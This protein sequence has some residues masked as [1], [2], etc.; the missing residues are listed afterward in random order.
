M[1]NM[2]CCIMWIL[3]TYLV[4]LHSMENN[5]IPL[6]INVLCDYSVHFGYEYRNVWKPLSL[7]NTHYYKKINDEFFKKALIA[8]YLPKLIAPIL[9]AL[10]DSPERK[11]KYNATAT[12]CAWKQ[13]F[14]SEHLSAIITDYDLE[15]QTYTL[16]YPDLEVK[17]AF[18]KYLLEAFAQ[19]DALSVKRLSED[20]WRSLNNANADEVI[21]V[22]KQLFAHVPYQLHMKEEKFY[23]ALLQ[24]A[25]ST[26]GLKAQ[27]EYSTSDGR[28]DLILELSTLIYII[29]VKFN[30]KAKEALAQIEQKKYYERFLSQ[31]KKI[32]LVGLSFTREPG[33]FD[34]AYAVKELQ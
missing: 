30:K 12:A 28:I 9:P 17:I 13:P 23:H 21:A 34:I 20:L 15:R 11:V 18:Q 1:K 5:T 2:H 29:E 14:C 31:K 4:S 19:L 7:V 22:I 27:S 3:V 16:D 32:I 25:F 10:W 24:M 33:Y 6:G 26:A 8:S